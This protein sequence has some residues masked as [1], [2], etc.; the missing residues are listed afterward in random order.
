MEN[1]EGN[2]EDFKNIIS[3]VMSALPSGAKI[4]E[5]T[6]ISLDGLRVFAQQLNYG[7]SVQSEQY[8]TKINGGDA[9]NVFGVSNEASENMDLIEATPEELSNIKEILKP[10][11]EKFGID[12]ID[13]AVTITNGNQVSIK[14][15]I[16]TKTV[17]IES[18]ENTNNKN[19]FIASPKTK[20]SQIMVGK[21]PYTN[22]E[23]NLQQI[24]NVSKNGNQPIFGIIKNGSLVTNKEKDI[25]V[26]GFADVSNKEGRLYLLLP[27][28]AGKYSPV[29]VRVKHFNETEF[30]LNDIAV[31]NTPIGKS[32]SEAIIAL[33]ES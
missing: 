4:Y 12:N 26:V 29:A 18:V 21:I 31:A 28:A 17:N 5:R 30:D 15:P 14:L 9:A 24:P 19:K 16:L 25:E 11:L 27:N 7:F 6:S 22:E 3:S 2:K 1:K 20:V 13:E 10:Y 23:K 8:E 32:I 33:A